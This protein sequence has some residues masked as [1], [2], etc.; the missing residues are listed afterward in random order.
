MVA[1][2]DRDAVAAAHTFGQQTVGERV[3]R[4]VEFLGRSSSPSS[5]MIAVRSGVR[6]ALSDGIMPISPHFAMSATIA[7]MF[8]GGSS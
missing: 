1:G 6:R 5:S 8:C 7:A 4:V 3:G 2:Q